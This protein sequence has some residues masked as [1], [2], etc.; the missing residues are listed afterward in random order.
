MSSIEDRLR[1]AALAAAGTVADGSAP[2]LRL[3]RR[4]LARFPAMLRGRGAALAAPAAAVAVA[5]IVVAVSLTARAPGHGSATGVL[6]PAHATTTAGPGQ[7]PRYSV[8]LNYVG[9]YKIWKIDRTDAV[10]TDSRSSAAIATL[11]PPKPY[12]A[13]VDVTG[14]DTPDGQVFVLAAQRLK[15]PSKRPEGWPSTRLYELRVGP[16]GSGA[17]PRLTA[18]PIPVFAP[19]YF[20]DQAMALSPDGRQLAVGQNWKQG[21]QWESGLSLYNMQTGAVRRWVLPGA[22]LGYP[23]LSVHSPSWEANGRL[24][25]LDTSSGKCLDCV[26]LLN[27]AATGSLLDASRLLVRSPNLHLQ[28]D[29][30]ATLISPDGSTVLRSAVLSIPVGH[31]EFYDVARLYFYAARSGRLERTMY[32]GTHNVDQTLLWSGGGRTFILARSVEGEGPFITGSLYGP[33]YIYRVALPAQAQ[34]AAW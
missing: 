3:P 18:L 1:L 23:I 17:K 20:G 5:A 10:V 28:V 13:F 6:P 2:P 24:I 16:S 31:H 11:Q 14:A 25:A 12:N 4:R 22:Q 21:K 26:R 8:A 19:L 30:D 33:G 34:Q 27:T 32:F 7:P 29:W 9:Q 15:P